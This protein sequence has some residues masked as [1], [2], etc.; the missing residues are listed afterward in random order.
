MRARDRAA[1]V[2]R[3]GVL[4]AFIDL[5]LALSPVVVGLAL[6]LLYGADGW[7]GGWLDDHGIQVLFALPVDGHRDD[8]RL[9]PVRR[10]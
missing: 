2:P 1:E 6:F 9:A 8:L 7:F 4:N 3:Q 10:P 5:P